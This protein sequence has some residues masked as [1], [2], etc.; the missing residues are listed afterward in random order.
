M[1]IEIL[2]PG[3]AKCREMYDA[4]CEA[5]KQAGLEAEVIKI[6]KLDEIVKRGVMLTPGLVIDGKVVS[7]GKPLDTKQIAALLPDRT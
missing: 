6:E 7:S 3:C 4:A 2:G 5:V 1:K